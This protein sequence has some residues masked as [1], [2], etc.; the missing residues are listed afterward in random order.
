MQA[1][2]AS[3]ASFVAGASLPLLTA[4]LAPVPAIGPTVAAVSLAGLAV[5]GTVSAR[6][7]GAPWVR[8]TL[9]VTCLGALAFMIT[10]AAG[11]LVGGVR[12]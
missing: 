2:L 8:A 5:L 1:A 11:T 10:A 3:A 7:G 4:A 9:R 12:P 6:L